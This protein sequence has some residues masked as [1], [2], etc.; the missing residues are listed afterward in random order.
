MKKGQSIDT[1]ETWKETKEDVMLNLI[2]VKANQ[3]Q[4]FRKRLT[5]TGSKDIVENTNNEYWG[6]G[7]TGTGKNV[8]G[9]LLQLLRQKLVQE[10]LNS[11]NTSTPTSP[12]K[13]PEMFVRVN[14]VRTK[15]NYH[16]YSNIQPYKGCY[17]CGEEGHVVATCKHGKSLTCFKCYRQGHKANRCPNTYRYR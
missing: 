14:G 7:Q 2:Q 16:G 11:R 9:V 8:L 6:R 1:N 3:C 15:R 17:Y 10:D 12:T 13:S 5:S 4:T